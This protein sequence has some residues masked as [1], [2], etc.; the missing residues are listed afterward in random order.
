VTVEHLK[1]EVGLKLGVDFRNIR[2]TYGAKD[3]VD[4]S[5]LSSYF[6]PDQATLYLSGRLCG[7][8]D[9]KRRKL[10]QEAETFAK[11]D[12]EV[13]DLLGTDSDC[14]SDSPLFLRSRNQKAAMFEKKDVEVINLL[15]TDSDCDLDS[16]L[17]SDFVEEVAMTLASM[18]EFVSKPDEAPDEPVLCKSNGLLTYQSYHS[19]LIIHL[20]IVFLT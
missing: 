5:H 8:C 9:T 18:G 1:Q 7:G 4:N 14:D 10:D 12:V 3:L 19:V 17:L 16:P 2:L 20:F 11:K 13:I 15:G 6:L